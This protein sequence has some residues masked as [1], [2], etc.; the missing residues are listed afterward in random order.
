MRHA[1]RA[2]ALA[3]AVTTALL[4]APAAANGR[5]PA[6]R[7][8]V[9]GPGDDASVIAVQTTFGIALSTDGGRTWRALCEDAIGFAGMYDPSLVVARDGAVL[10]SLPDGLAVLRPT[11]C[12]FARPPTAP[13]VTVLDLAADPASGRIV[14]ALAPL[15]GPNGI[16]LSDDDGA[17]WHAGWSSAE[18]YVQTVDL[19]PGLP[20]RLYASGFTRAGAPVL[21]RSDDGGATFTETTRDFAGGQD[22]YIA[23]VDARRADTLL[24]RSNAH[25]GGTLLLRSDDGGT[26]F[27]E[28]VRTRAHMLGVA[29]VPGSETLWVAGSGGDDG[30]L[31]STD[32]G[33]TWRVV[34][35]DFTALCLRYHRGVLYACA[36]EALT[37]FALA[38]STDGGEHFTPL[39]AFEDLRGPDVCPAG[40][41][42]RARC[43][44][45][46]DALR[47]RLLFDAGVTRPPRCA[48]DAGCDAAVPHPALTDA[49]L[50]GAPRDSGRD[51]VAG[52]GCGCR[53]GR[54]GARGVLA[55]V[56]GVMA[57]WLARRRLPTP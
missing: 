22:A 39:L 49:G 24:V 57:A 9:A 36:D 41:Q 1:P 28:L 29:A 27:R 18:F 19:A 5:F 12:D 23:V 25:A 6:A 30:I 43:E 46:W 10:A 56:L 21:Y 54:R 8:L 53:A 34:N 20:S 13:A 14:A 42:V 7:Y 48:P 45:G 31:R 33:R 38:W 16:A 37:G 2:L 15:D 52:G 44:P 55:A 4:P 3:L 40:S 35:R 50:D 32:G 47:A 17:T 26:T 11:Y 51:T